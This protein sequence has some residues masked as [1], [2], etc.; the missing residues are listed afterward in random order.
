[1]TSKIVPG[2]LAAALSLCAC[3]PLAHAGTHSGE[4]PGIRGVFYHEFTGSFSGSE[5]FQVFPLAEPDRVHFG[6]IRAEGAWGATIE[7][8]SLTL[9]AGAGTGVIDDADTFELDLTLGAFTFHS[10]MTRA[11]FTDAGFPVLLDSPA[12]APGHAADAWAGV[13]TTHHP[14]TGAQLTSTPIAFDA[15]VDGSTV[16]LALDGLAVTGIWETPVQAGFRVVIPSALDL[17]YRTF[18]GSSISIT[19]NVLGELRLTGRNTMELTLLLQ[20][21]APVGFQSQ[22][23]VRA[24]LE[25][26]TLLDE[27]DVDGD[28]DLDSDD[29]AALDHALGTTSADDGYTILGDLDGD[30]D[31]DADDALRLSMILCPPDLAEPVGTLDFN[32]VVEFLGAFA[33]VD[34]RADFAEPFGILDFND[35]LA[36]L[37]R[38]SDGC[39]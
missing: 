21:R 25:R 17:R 15:T 26:A 12:P 9:D 14:M 1:M 7:G 29:R 16:T 19:R 36:F 4:E 28:G 2:G 31:I 34:F 10:E 30:G 8:P 39:P 23:I 3:V 20:T 27:G 38:F 35:V 32:D 18:P 37:S 33:I 13:Q 11:P 24:V 6:D 5:W 22:E